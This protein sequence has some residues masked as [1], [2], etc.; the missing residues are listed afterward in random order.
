MTR[1]TRREA[2]ATLA[3]ALAAGATALPCSAMAPLARTGRTPLRL[4]LSAYSLRKF[5]EYTP[6]G[7]PDAIDLLQF[8]DL[9]ADWGFA[10]VEPTSY[11]FPGEGVDE[12]TRELKRRCLLLGL[13]VSGGAIRNNF[14]LP[15]GAELDK[16]L[17]HVARWVDLYAELGAPVIRVFGGQPPRNV[18]LDA[19]IDN[20]V[21]NL[22]TACEQ[23]GRRGVTLAL[24]NHD[25]LTNI[26]VI[27]HIVERVD[28]PWFGVTWD[29]G[30]FRSRDPYADL[31]RL[32]PYAVNAQVKVAM[33]DDAGRESPADFAR[34]IDILRTADYRGYVVLEYE[35]A[36]D[37]YAAIPRH[38]EQLS[39]ALAAQ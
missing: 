27:L 25:F 16:E 7:D 5:L 11:Y 30:N 22:Q 34:L 26:D 6:A 23:A 39:Q 8:A 9:A 1:L 32:A 10:A 28:S 20:I 2:G 15:P 38:A 36:E 13:D 33:F 3:A 18:P 35:A 31:A 4:S 12:F 37:P 21:A 14:T 29:S 17:A 19:A 24:E